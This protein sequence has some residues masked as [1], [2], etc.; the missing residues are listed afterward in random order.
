[1]HGT[2]IVRAELERLFELEDLKTFTHNVLGFDPET[3][4]GTTAKA[5]FAGALTQFCQEHDAL[6]ALCDA[7]LATHTNVDE[8]LS[9]VLATGLSVDE[10][11]KVGDSFGQF[12]VTRLLGEGRLAFSAVA[13][14]EGKHYRLRVLRAE[15]TRDKR[16]LHRFLTLNR[17]LARDPQ[18]GLPKSTEAGEIGGRYYVAHEF[19]EG[20]TLATRIARTGP[21]H[22]NEARPLLRAVLEALSGLHKRRIAHGDLRLENVIAYRAADGTQR[23]VLLD[24]GSDRLRAR[25]RLANGRTELFAT[26]A[27]PKTVAPEQIKG[28]VADPRS[29]VYSF[30]ALVYELV[31]GKSPFGET[32]LDAAFGHLSKDAPPP[33][34]VAPRGWVARDLDDFVLRLMHKEPNKRP[35]DATL[36]ILALE[37]VGRAVS[38]AAAPMS[39]AE[40]DGMIDKMMGEPDNEGIAMQLES[41]AEGEIASRVA[42]AF[43]MAADVADDRAHKKSLLF[44]AAR[45]Y[46]VRDDTLAQ[47]EDVYKQL[48]ELD[49]HERVALS[50]LETVRKRLGKYEELIETLLE[51]SEAAESKSERARLMSEIGR[52]YAGDLE[53]REQALVAYTQAFCE[54]PTDQTVAAEIERLAGNK[55]EAWNEVLTACAE[56]S[57]DESRGQE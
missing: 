4:G 20:Q 31:S 30:G 42:E 52:I 14:K 24:A 8:R 48:I 55:A 46:A 50:G 40:V 29:D 13:E 34:S 33:S 54:G 25:P 27:S 3:V 11:L 17:L 37:Q 12:V 10:P 5:S 43:T 28:T 39:A 38:Q 2:E 7:L 21:L 56:A 44:R 22:I 9:Q 45:I 51:R 53:D 1:M 32:A 41:I 23:I 15:A 19:V 26:A 36:V 35:A 6:E 18:E 47:A 57:Q 49:P 16:G